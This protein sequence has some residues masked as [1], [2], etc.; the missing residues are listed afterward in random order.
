MSDK[1]NNHGIEKLL[2][3]IDNTLKWQSSNLHK[4]VADLLYPRLE[5]L[6]WLEKRLAIKGQLPP[7]SGWPAAPDFLLRLHTWVCKHKPQVVVETGSGV[8]TLVIADALRQNGSG[9]LI[10]LEHLQ[11][12]ADKTNETLKDEALTAWVELRV[13]VLVPWYGEHLNPADAEKSSRWYSLDLEGIEQINLLIVDGP[14]GATCLYARYPAL[15]AFFEWLAPTAE[16][17]MDDANRQEEKDISEAWAERYGF[18][19][20]LIPLEKGMSRLWRAG[21]V[22]PAAPSAT[23]DTS[24]RS[25]GLDFSIGR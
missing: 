8:T 15:P 23:V 6:L 1:S 25:L 16:I 17:W 19:L 9:K 11:E 24:E 2:R 14:P 18:E 12:Y 10:S 13:G 7:L 3:E 5:S 20:E 21:G 4:K 22:T